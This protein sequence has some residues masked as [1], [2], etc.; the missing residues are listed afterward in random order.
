MQ[1][2]EDKPISAP[3]GGD[4]LEVAAFGVRRD[5][6]LAG[7]KAPDGMTF[8]TVDV[9]AR[10]LVTLDGDATVYDPKARPGSKMKIGTV[11]DWKDSRK[12]I[13]L[14]VDGEYG[15]PPLDQ[16]ATLPQQ[17]R[18]LPDLMT[19]GDV[20]FLAPESCTSLELRCDFPNAA[21]PGR[22]VVRPKGLTLTVEGTRPQPPART[23]IVSIK[24]DIFE[25]N[26]V[27]QR[28]SDTFAG[29]SAGS[30]SR[31]LL[32]DVTVRNTG[33]QGEFFQTRRQIKHV[34]ENGGQSEFD[35]VT[36]KGPHAPSDLLW[37]PPGEQRSFEAIFKIPVKETKP[38]L[39][40]SGVS[41]AQILTLS[42]IDSG[43][44]GGP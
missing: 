4:V 2:S 32:L 21:I 19:G 8:I 1:A 16:R 26:V 33:A 29:Q 42:Q 22:G 39:A 43:Q 41:L 20:V 30:G 25:F 3:Q 37:I 13:Q 27:G 44:I 18:F 38:R 5:Q 24:D 15:Y 12:Y 23:P 28:V 36:L 10:S 34:A 9:R 11:A 40:Y 17:P 7:T 6:E 31:F 35:P 14:V